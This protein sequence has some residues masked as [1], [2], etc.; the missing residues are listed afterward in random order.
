MQFIIKF[1]PEITVKSRPVRKQMAKQLRDNLR[2]LLKPIDANIEI[3][4]EWDQLTVITRRSEAAV[5]AGVIEVLSN[6]PGIAY[7]IDVQQ[8]ELRDLDDIYQKTAAL[9]AD[10]LRGKTLAVRCKRSGTHDFSSL[11]VERYV[12]G[13]LMQHSGARGVDLRNPDELVRIDVRDN[14][15]YIVNKRY[16]GIGGFPIGSQDSVVSL[17]SGGFDSTVASYFT[18]RRGMRTHFCF[19]NLGGRQHEL[20]VK[21]VAYYLWSKYGASSRVKFVA[22]PFD[23]VVAQILK[24]VDDSQ[25]GVI[26]KRMMLR[27]A[28]RVAETLGAQ[29][30][31]TGEA[32]AQVSSQTLVNLTVIDRATD[33]LVLRPLITMAKAEIINTAQQIGTADYAA[34]MPEYCG[35]ISVKPTTRAKLPKVEYEETK[36]D[37]AVLE[38]AFANAQYLNIDEV[39]NPEIDAVNVET[40]S[41]VEILGAPVFDAVIVDVRHPNEVERK[42]LAAGNVRVE[43]IPFYELQ[44][45]FTELDK[46]KTYLLYCD[47]GVMSKLHAAHLVE[48]GYRNIK[49][50][51]PAS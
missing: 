21:E 49:V 4:R 42:P 39:A 45:K 40:L 18:I 7:S 17:L 12:G 43:K 19:F 16:P 48:Q 32:V 1:F 28:T 26:L 30:L 14:C 51:R 20:G 31:V 35:V 23:E 34:Q 6:T 13:L 5:Q 33:M 41:D 47:K 36:F 24:N 15:L 27:V 50:Y 8:Y 3:V 38:R 29:A 9:W 10:R 22:V 37:F 44:T 11:D 46:A 2:T 25:M